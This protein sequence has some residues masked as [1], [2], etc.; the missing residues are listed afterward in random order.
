M[1][2]IRVQAA[3]AGLSYPVDPRALLKS[4]RCLLKDAVSPAK[5]ARAV[6]PQHII[7]PHIDFRVNLELYAS[8]YSLFLNARELPEIFYILGVGHQ[9]PHEFSACRCNYTTPLGSVLS[10]NDCLEFMQKECG[11]D[12]E[13]SPATFVHEHSL[14]Y[15]VIWLQALRD[16]FFPGHL[17]RIV[18]VLMG[19]LFETV[20]SGCLPDE[21]DEI[22]RFGQ[23]LHRS[24]QTHGKGRAACIAS[25]DGCHVGPRF[26]H[27]FEGLPPVQKAVQ[28]WEK[29]L[30]QNCRTDRLDHFINHI[31]QVQNGF[32]FDGLGVLTCL[33][34]NFHLKAT[35]MSHGIW[36]EP[37]DQSFVTF[38]SGQLT[39][40]SSGLKQ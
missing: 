35:G 30:W 20:Q 11:S 19:G 38:S 3:F 16:L 23:A 9:C 34:R 7:V 12:I 13:R 28:A 21:D 36:Y 26:D 40:L 24:F 8:S 22:T 25:I 4:F 14:E 37:G 18:P 5:H 1:K 33:L 10:D 31:S 32:Y 2:S 29:K 39:A 27:A 17:F 6:S 15:V